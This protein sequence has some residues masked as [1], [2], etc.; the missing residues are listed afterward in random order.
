MQVKI[1]EFIY[2]LMINLEIYE[3]KNI[4]LLEMMSQHLG[5]LTEI[6]DWNKHQHLR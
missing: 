5:Q 4:L 3:G 2:F 6:F 1:C